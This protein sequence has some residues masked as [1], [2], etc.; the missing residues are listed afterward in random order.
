VGQADFNLSNFVFRSY[1]YCPHKNIRKAAEKG[2]YLNIKIPIFP[3]AFSVI[4]LSLNTLTGF[5]NFFKT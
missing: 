2:R 5:F 1:G 4:D 3:F